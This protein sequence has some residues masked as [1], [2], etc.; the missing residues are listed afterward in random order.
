MFRLVLEKGPVPTLIFFSRSQ[1]ASL[2]LFLASLQPDQVLRKWR[3]H[4]ICSCRSNVT[5]I[6][7]GRRDSSFSSFEGSSEHLNCNVSVACI[8]GLKYMAT[9]FFSRGSIKTNFKIRT[10]S[11]FFLPFWAE[12]WVLRLNCVFQMKNIKFHGLAGFLFSRVCLFRSETLKQLRKRCFWENLPSRERRE[13]FFVIR[14]LESRERFTGGHSPCANKSFFF[15]FH[16]I[17][18]CLAKQ[19]ATKDGKTRLFLYML[20]CFLFRPLGWV[21]KIWK[22]KLWSPPFLNVLWSNLPVHGKTGL[23]YQWLPYP[24]DSLCHTRDHKI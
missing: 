5:G 9:F 8:G 17:V 14:D 15:T 21:R 1:E 24:K 10:K 11:P 3:V 13:E 7:N 12:I 16:L 18:F 19:T 2:L 23:I 22:P 6:M 4:L 20:A